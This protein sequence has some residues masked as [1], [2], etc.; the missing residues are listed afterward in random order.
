M[1][2]AVLRDKAKYFLEEF[3]MFHT[4]GE[5]VLLKDLRDKAQPFNVSESKQ[6]K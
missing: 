1:K 2:L 3:K 5:S 6:T 4:R